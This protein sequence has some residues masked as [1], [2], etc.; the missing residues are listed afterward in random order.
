[1]GC[2]TE[3]DYDTFDFFDNIIKYIESTDKLH[4]EATTL[5]R[6]DNCTTF[7][8]QYTSSKF[9]IGKNVCEL[10]VKLYKLL[11]NV[12]NK[13]N[14]DYKK[15]WHFLNYWLNFNISKNKLNA[16]TCATNFSEGLSHHCL[17]T[18]GIDFP[19]P[20]SIY[21]IT[22]ENLK[23]MSLLY[24]LYENYRI[25]NNIL[26]TSPQDKPGLLLEPSTKCCSYYA[27]A[28]YLCNDENNKFCTQLKKFKTTYEEL[29][30]TIDRKDPEYSKNFIKLTQCNNNTMSTALVGTT[31][32]L[33]PLLVG[34]YK[35]TPLR[36]LMKFKKG[37]LTEQYTNNDDEMR[38]IMLMDQR[39][40]H[41]SSQQETYNIKYQS[42]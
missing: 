18:L 5:D 39:S 12:N 29:Y 1:M 23:K 20:S 19:P 3:I 17:N 38:N 37:K 34:I 11:P 26:I 21:N 24:G 14:S 32:G 15:E 36:Q 8:H 31:I 4:S 25:L 30:D 10:F 28:N 40:K 2:N 41:I 13:G 33:V 9:D 6:E 16:I 42:L 22:E 35:F 7:S 27:E